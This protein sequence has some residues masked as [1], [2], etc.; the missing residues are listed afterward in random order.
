MNGTVRRQ[1]GSQYLPDYVYYNADI[2][3][4]TADDFPTSDTSA[5]YNETRDM[6]II[7]DASKYRF[8]VI[9]VSANG[10]GR[11]LPMFIPSIQT[12]AQAN[13]GVQTF[14]TDVNL[15]NYGVAF[16]LQ[17]VY[18]YG[19]SPSFTYVPVTINTPMKYASFIP[20]YLQAPTP[21]FSSTIKN[22]DIS[23]Q[24]YWVS[25][26]QAVLNMLNLAIYNPATEG[27]KTPTVNPGYNDGAWYYLY[28]ALCAAVSFTP[29]TA[30]FLSQYP[31][32]SVFV[33]YFTPPQWIYNQATNTFNLLMDSRGFGVSATSTGSTA[34]VPYTAGSNTNIFLYSPQIRMFMNTNLY[35][36]FASIPVKNWGSQSISAIIPSISMGTYTIPVASATISNGVYCSF[37]QY[38]VTV[39][40]PYE[41]QILNNNYQNIIDYRL[42]PYSGVSPLGYVP[43]GQQ[44]VYWI[45][46]Q[47]YAT[48]ESLWSPVEGL[49]L[50]T[51][52]IP[53][54]KEYMS[55][56]VPLGASDIGISAPTSSSAFEPILADFRLDLSQRGAQQY[57]Q[58][59]S[60][61]PIAE[62]RLSDFASSREDIHSIDIKMWWRNR[63]DG[64]LYPVNMFNLSSFSVKMMFKNKDI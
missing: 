3:N 52:L 36:L 43:T 18:K 56:G 51:N 23:T 63:L 35:G 46:S 30:G 17:G 1:G 19:T 58:Y 57:R 42:A 6:P 9:N 22:Q 4:G 5:S 38:G 37:T 12:K 64:K 50:T 41:V 25:N 15:T 48:T 61:D 10:I 11:N 32:L 21:T 54:R 13:T 31:T 20:E 26:Y 27:N 16:S 34:L 53:L 47:D 8:S 24:Y 45:V 44:T 29:G 33:N 40:Y 14:A 7:S 59:F 39:V 60:F 2:I 28:Y 62:F 55:A 49:Y